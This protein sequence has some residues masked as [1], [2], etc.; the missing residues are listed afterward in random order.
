MVQKLL[1]DKKD[2]KVKKDK[3]DKKER[4][5][6]KYE[7]VCILFCDYLFSQIKN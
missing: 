1:K 4:K 6:K 5:D 3:K 7:K 2:T